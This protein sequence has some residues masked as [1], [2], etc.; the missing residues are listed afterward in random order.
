LLRNINEKGEINMK[1]LVVYYSYEGN[2]DMIAQEIQKVNNSE[3]LRLRPIKEMKSKGFSK[4]IW[5]GKQVIMHEKP[6]LEPINKNIEDYD[7]III[8][9]P[10]WASTFAPAVNTFLSEYK[11]KN[12][13][14]G[15]FCCSSGGK[16]KVF[17]KL[18]NVLEGNH[19][20]GEIE[21]IDPLTK[22]KENISSKVEEWVNSLK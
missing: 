12:K 17:E 5:G 13:N 15:L 20:I 2:C 1:S 8:G 3:L 7:L 11:L 19:I 18:E 4:F 16:G 21:F 14:I 6:K 9:T 10:V 22:R